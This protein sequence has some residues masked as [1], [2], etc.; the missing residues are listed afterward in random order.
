[1]SKGSINVTTASGG[2][3]GGAGGQPPHPTFRKSAQFVGN[4]RLCR[5]FKRIKKRKLIEKITGA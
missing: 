1:M 5:K 3:S 4:F 2:N